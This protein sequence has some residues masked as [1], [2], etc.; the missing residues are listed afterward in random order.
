[1]NLDWTPLFPPFLICKTERRYT[2][3]HTCTV[4]H[5]RQART[6]FLTHIYKNQ[7]T[8]G[9]FNP[10]FPPTHTQTVLT[11]ALHAAASPSF[12]QPQPPPPPHQH[13]HRPQTVNAPHASTPSR[14]GSQPPPPPH[15]PHHHH[16][17]QT[18]GTCPCPHGRGCGSAPGSC[19]CSRRPA[20]G[21]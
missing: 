6:L 3:T 5:K 16:R 21:R 19:P 10:P 11:T 15:H 20:T 18:S 4:R 1:M 12:S 9:G 8:H 14:H 2:C 17:P 13:H 7:P